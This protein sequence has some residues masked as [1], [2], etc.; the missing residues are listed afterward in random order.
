M[1]TC[2][3]FESSVINS[4]YSE[5]QVFS[6]NKT[7]PKL[8]NARKSPTGTRGCLTTLYLLPNLQIGPIG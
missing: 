5:Q 7:I 1:M 4:I 6:H 2:C 8:S 3:T